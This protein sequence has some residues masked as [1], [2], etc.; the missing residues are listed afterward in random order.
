MKKW[1]PGAPGP[2]RMQRV[3]SEAVYLPEPCRK[4]LGA[5]CAAGCWQAQVVAAGAPERVHLW[6]DCNTV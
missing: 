3:S 4:D 1:G 5:P 6:V 2:V